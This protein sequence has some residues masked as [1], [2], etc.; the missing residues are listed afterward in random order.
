MMK[1]WMQIW[2]NEWMNA[3]NE[4]INERKKDICYVRLKAWF[5]SICQSNTNSSNSKNLNQLKYH[6]CGG[7]TFKK[8]VCPSPTAPPTQ[9]M[10]SHSLL[11]NFK[12]I[13]IF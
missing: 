7:V 12:C 1:G 10:F 8:L 4:R 2:K 6:C 9:S 3:K 11:K 13:Q 5:L